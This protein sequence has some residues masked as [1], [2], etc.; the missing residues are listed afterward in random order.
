VSGPGLYGVDGAVED[1]MEVEVL[2]RVD[3]L[4]VTTGVDEEEEAPALVCW[5]VDDAEAEADAGVF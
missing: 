3:V 4:V 5:G 1:E 2:C